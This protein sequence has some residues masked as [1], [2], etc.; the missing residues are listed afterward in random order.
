MF[1]FFKKKY[2]SINITEFEALQN[3]NDLV[4]I[5]VRNT[6][7]LSSGIIPKSIHINVMESSFTSKIKK[8][9]PSKTY[10]MYCRSGLRSAR[11][12][13]IMAQNEFKDLYNLKGGIIAWV[14]AR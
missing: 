1:S 5:D 8:L 2:Q 10:L 3:D 7:E 11:A 6:G 14:K 9:D 13:Q 12:C 4:V